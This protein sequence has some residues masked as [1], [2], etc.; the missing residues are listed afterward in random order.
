MRSSLSHTVDNITSKVDGLSHKVLDSEF[1][2][3]A[4]ST[5]RNVV[6]K[7]RNVAHIGKDRFNE[8]LDAGKQ[9]VNESLEIGKEAVN[10]T[11][12]FGKQRFADSIEAGW[13]EYNRTKN[14]DIAR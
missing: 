13:A 14:R 10:D 12:E 3:Q 9:R 2:H 6:E 8:S 7:G 4:T 5:L 1:G 11:L